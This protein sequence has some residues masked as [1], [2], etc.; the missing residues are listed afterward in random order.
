MKKPKPPKPFPTFAAMVEKLREY[1]L[2]Y[3]CETDY[4]RHYDCESH[5]CRDEGICRCSTIVDFEIESLHVDSIASYLSEKTHW[6][7]EPDDLTRYMLERLLRRINPQDLSYDI[8]HSYY[9][10]EVSWIKVPNLPK[11]PDDL[12]DAMRQ[13]LMEEYGWVKP[14][15]EKAEFEIAKNVPITD[16][17]IPNKGHYQKLDRKTVEEYKAKPPEYATCLCRK[18]GNKYGIVDGYHRYMA[19][20][21]S[22]VKTIDLVWFD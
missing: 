4:S 20:S 12:D 19:A 22:G 13:L 18:E 6:I 14:E 2:S 1:N 3:S 5:G 11:F 7:S 21:E 10:E 16:V 17:V 15:L 8:R 9:G